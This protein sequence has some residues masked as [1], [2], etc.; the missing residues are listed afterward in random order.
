MKDGL[1]VDVHPKV[2]FVPA[3]GRPGQAPFNPSNC[4][5]AEPW[6]LGLRS[7][8]DARGNE[9]TS[10]VRAAWTAAHVP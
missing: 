5:I 2:I 4:R 6:L 8:L 3:W 9:I 1:P 10:N 7:S